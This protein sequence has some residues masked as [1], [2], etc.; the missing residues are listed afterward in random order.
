MPPAT[1]RIR[2]KT[3]PWLRRL[4]PTRLVVAR[5]E[6]RGQRM[7]ERSPL[8]REDA[9]AMMQTIVAGTPR[10]DELTELA[11]RHLIEREAAN[12]IFWQPWVNRGID[13]RSA[14]LLQ[15]T[16]SQ[17]RGVLLSTCH[18]GPSPGASSVVRSLGHVPYTVAGPWYFEQPSRDLWGRRLAHWR[19]EN[20][21]SHLIRSTGSFATLLALL[22]RGEC[23]YLC[24]DLPGSHQTQF[25]GRPTMLGDGSARLAVQSDALVLPVHSYRVGHRARLDVGAPLDP[26]RFAGADELHDAL[27]AVHE[28]RMLE[29]PEEMEDPR[30][31]GW[32]ATAAEWSRPKPPAGTE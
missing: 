10:A 23:V 3:S 6:R 25:L 26:R 1:L 8:A 11:R 22:E 13:K 32:E 2:V 18:I 21:G 16:L 24:F 17:Q 7:W 28:R 4:L 20:R 31:F 30:S 15:E 9:V 14:E 12:A 19:K 29:H 5:A 27:A